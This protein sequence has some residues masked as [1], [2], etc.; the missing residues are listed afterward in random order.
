MIYRVRRFGKVP[1]MMD[2]PCLICNANVI[3]HC[4]GDLGFSLPLTASAELVDVSVQFA[5]T[6]IPVLSPVRGL[7]SFLCVRAVVTEEV[8]QKDRRRSRS[9]AVKDDGLRTLSFPRQVS[10]C[11]DC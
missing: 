9:V 2:L 5:V 11:D 10:E 4:L 8:F 6:A 3:F 1:E 7:G